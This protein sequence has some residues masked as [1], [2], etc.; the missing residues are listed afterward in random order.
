MPSKPRSLLRHVHQLNRWDP[1]VFTPWLINDIT[2]GYLKPFMLEALQQWPRDFVHGGDR[3]EFMPGCDSIDER[4]AVLD[5]IVLSLVEQGI[6]RQHINEIYPVT[7]TGGRLDL[8]A[9]LDRGAAG[10]FG[11]RTYGQHINGLMR[12]A[13]S[14]RIWV[15]RRDPSRVHFPDKLDNIVAGGL[16]QNLGMAENLVKECHEE[17]DIDSHL[18]LQAIPVGAISYRRENDFGLK[19]DTL[20]CYDLELPG[21]FQPRNTDGEVAEF[22]LLEADEVVQRV[23]DSDDFKLNCNLVFIDLFIRHGLIGPNDPEYLELVRGLHA[24]N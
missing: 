7:G 20:Y 14:L 18:A 19:P 10:Y 9:R 2:V 3:L 11:I 21:D 13:D 5:S 8:Y 16:P 1:Q 12:D 17:A 4:S 6:I 22:M 15:A 24:I 23:R